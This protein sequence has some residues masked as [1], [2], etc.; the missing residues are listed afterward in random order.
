M[1]TVPC[2]L[3]IDG[4]FED[5]FSKDFQI[6]LE[7]LP[8]LNFFSTFFYVLRIFLAAFSVA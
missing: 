3:V 6:F 7:I 4:F 8:L 2:M 5:F 1:T